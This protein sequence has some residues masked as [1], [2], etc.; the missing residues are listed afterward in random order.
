MAHA[1]TQIRNLLIK[2][3]TGLPTTGDNVFTDLYALDDIKKL[4]CL[5]IETRGDTYDRTTIGKP[6]I[7]DVI[8]E[9]KIYAGVK[10]T[11]TYQDTVDQIILEVQKA[12]NQDVTLNQSV[13]SVIISNI[14]VTLMYEQDKPIAIGDIALNINYRI[15]EDDPETIII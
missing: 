12:I 10:S 2:T 7:L 15:R 9:F 8:T 13:R 14:D 4:P 11:D 5:A 6:A 1:R 3:L